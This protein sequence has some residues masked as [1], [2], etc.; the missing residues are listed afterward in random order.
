[1][2]R[3]S[4]QRIIWS[5]DDDDD[6]EFPDL[7]ALVSRRKYQLPEG[8]DLTTQNENPRSSSKTELAEKTTSAIRRR[9]LGPITDNLLLKAWTPE[10][11]EAGEEHHGAGQRKGSTRPKGAGVELRTRSTR[12]AAS[13]LPPPSP[14][15]EDEEYVSAQEEVTIIEDVSVFDDTFHSCDSEDSDFVDG[16]TTEDEDVFADA[17][18]RRPRSRPRLGPTDKKPGPRA[19]ENAAERTW[20]NR[21]ENSG[22]GRRSAAKGG[23]SLQQDHEPQLSKT[24]RVGETRMEGDRDLATSMSKLR[25][26][27]MGESEGEMAKS[28]TS[29]TSDRETTPPSTP[30]KPRAGLVSPKK[31]PRIPITPHRPSSDLFWSQ[32]FVDDWN[33]EHSPRKQLFPDAVAAR[34]T[35]PAKTTTSPEKPAQ[36][37]TA[38]GKKV[39]DREAKRAFEARKRELAEAF[40]RELDTVITQGKLAELAEPTGGIRV[41]WTNKLN[42]TA[43]R[44]NWKRETVRTRQADGTTTTSHRHHASIELAEKVI[45]DAH[46]LRNVLAHEFCHL[47]NFMVSGVTTNPHGR[48]FKAWAA[49]CSRA[50]ADRGVQVTTKH[51]YDIDF[52]YVWECVDC[53]T[54]FK[55]HSRSIDP[56]R[57]RCG[58]CRGELKQIKPAPRGAG[59]KAGGGGDGEAAKGKVVSEYQAFMKEQMRLIRE[60]NPKSP[61]KEIMKIVASRWAAKKGAAS[62]TPPDEQ[63]QKL[64]EGLEDLAV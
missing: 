29:A 18:P 8:S 25:L 30:P 36:K 57:H 16:E 1:M 21:K 11:A 42:T 52:K 23:I 49:K 46:R 38:G 20:S 5:D 48:E 34:R 17:P 7:D 15:D 43:G 61:Q 6:D 56:A 35:S 63:V 22:T 41:V 24:P 54:E 2:T 44:A 60:E 14:R 13:P 58:R 19:A 53:F 12:S 4:R 10:S 9:K 39:S 33:D 59:K 50:F 26:K 62:A 27:Q 28:G 64:E 32:E 51:S 40:L 37:K 47:A 45:D 31:L 3:L 55:R